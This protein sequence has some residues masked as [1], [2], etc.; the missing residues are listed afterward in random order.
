MRT[1]EEIEAA[2]AQLSAE[3][4]ARFRAWFERFEAENWDRQLQQDVETGRLDSLADQALRC[5]TLP[6]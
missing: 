3:E 5:R 1:A 4:L 6:P 2:V